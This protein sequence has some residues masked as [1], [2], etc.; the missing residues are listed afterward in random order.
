MSV[1]EVAKQ[2]NDDIGKDID[3]FI[4]ENDIEINYKEMEVLGNDEQLI[5]DESLLIQAIVSKLNQIGYV[6]IDFDNYNNTFNS[7]FFSNNNELF[8]DSDN[9][10]LIIK[11]K[12]TPNKVILDLWY[13]IV[14][15]NQ[16]IYHKRQGMKKAKYQFNFSTE[17]FEQIN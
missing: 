8:Y 3:Q 2:L 5:S 9:N 16:Y 14:N 15:N 11:N 10:Y 1:K 17:N 13:E 7:D 6:N 4:K 12:A